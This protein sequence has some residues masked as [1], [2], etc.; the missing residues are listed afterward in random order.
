MFQEQQKPHVIDID[1][2][3][4]ECETASAVDAILTE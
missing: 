4:Y 2:K 1:R 3:I